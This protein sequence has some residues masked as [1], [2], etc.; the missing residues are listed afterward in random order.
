MNVDEYLTHRMTL[1]KEETAQIKDPRVFDF[2]YV[3]EQPLPRDEAKPIIDALLKYA[4][5]VVPQPPAPSELGTMIA[6][7]AAASAS[8]TAAIVMRF[9]GSPSGCLNALIAR[10]A[11]LPWGEKTA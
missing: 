2:S 11:S 3:P 6:G 1:L 8:P 9:M 4:Q 7:S 10:G 5:T